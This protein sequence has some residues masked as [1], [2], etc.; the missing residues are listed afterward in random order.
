L[1]LLADWASD[2]RVQTAAAIAITIA[3][4]IA[5]AAQIRFWHRR[6]P[7]FAEDFGICLKASDRI[8]QGHNP[9]DDAVEFRRLLRLGRD[10]NSLTW[11][12]LYPPVVAVLLQPVAQADFSLA[13]RIWVGINGALLL[14]GVWLAARAAA[15]SRAWMAIPLVAASS[16]MWTVRFNFFLGNTEALIFFLIALTAWSI[17]NG[18]TGAAGAALGTA[19]SIK[20]LPVFLLPAAAWHCGRRFTVA[21]IATAAALTT[22]GFAFVGTEGVA[23]FLQALTVKG[24]MAGWPYNQSLNGLLHRQWVPSPANTLF[25]SETP[26]PGWVAP[27]VVAATFAVLG[28]YARLG[29]ARRL[30]PVSALATASATLVIVNPFNEAYYTIALLLPLAT[31]I[32]AAL[33]QSR[34]K[35]LLIFSTLAVALFLMG[36]RPSDWN[37]EFAM[38]GV[39]EAGWWRFLCEIAPEQFWQNLRISRVWLGCAAMWCAT[40][41]GV[42]CGL[43]GGRY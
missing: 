15:P 43:R 20:L 35:Q 36:V 25:Q 7:A 18:R 22:L 17:R 40:L 28:V 16:L 23:G 41:A 11:P 14:A 1:K 13:S 26:H 33:E 42:L 34:N 8:A 3:A 30:T 12:C 4:A 32:D 21:A 37:K 27:C 2:R 38:E 29:F 5:W 19:I 10:P 31:T 6:N 24:E 9:Y 39:R